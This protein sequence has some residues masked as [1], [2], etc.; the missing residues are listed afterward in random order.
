[1]ERQITILSFNSL[2]VRDPDSPES[3][4]FRRIRIRIAQIH[5]ESWT[6]GKL[7]TFT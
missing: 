4:S 6:L 1:M 2:S 3:T 5:L 7:D